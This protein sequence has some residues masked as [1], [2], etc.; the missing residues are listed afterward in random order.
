MGKSG[1]KTESTVTV[2][3]LFQALT[4]YLSVFAL[5][6][7]LLGTD[8][9]GRETVLNIVLFVCLLRLYSRKVRMNTYRRN[10]CRIF[11]GILSAVFVVGREVYNT[12]SAAGLF[13]ALPAILCTVLCLMGFYCL[14][15][16]LLGYPVRWLETQKA[17]PC[18]VTQWKLFR[19]RWRFLL[20]WGFIFLCWV[21]AFLAYYPG[22]LSYDSILQHRQVVGSLSGL[23]FAAYSNHHPPVH[24]YIWELFFRLGQHTY[25]EAI[26]MYAAVQMVILSLSFALVICYLIDRKWANWAV[27]LALLFVSVNP[28]MC[29]FSVSMT[30]DVYFTAAFVVVVLRLAQLAD[31]PAAFAASPVRMLSLG[32]CALMMCL[33]RNN[34]VYVLILM[35]PV[36]CLI[37]RKQWKQLLIS[38]GTALV[39]YFLIVGPGYSAL[40]I[41]SR[42]TGEVLSI[43]MQQ[44]ARVVTRREGELTE[45]D[46][47]EL[48][49]FLNYETYGAYNPRFA[50][51]VKNDFQDDYYQEH[52][53]EFFRLWLR[54]LK[55]FPGEYVDA[56][57]S[58]NVPYVFPDSATQDAYAQRIYIE[59]ENYMKPDRYSK[60]PGLLAFYRHFASYDA[61]KGIPLVSNLF[62][63]A[64]PFWV[65]L[66]GLFLLMVGMDWSGMTVILPG[67]LYQLT[68][69][70]GPVNNFRYVFPI[71]CIYPLI[72]C[73]IFSKKRN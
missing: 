61:V 71:F 29:I 21:P 9:F 62:S 66:F 4:A 53:S 16:R 32:F 43:P 57:L 55:R 65:M 45:E 15:D 48:G 12:N 68:F 46:K 10:C 59:Q 3:M 37:Y 27:V 64:A 42:N 60:L 38:C 51:P 18:R 50:D 39:L 63:T 17:S 19:C 47:E 11:A 44:L 73:V 67:L 1:R 5:D 40:G 54:L 7:Y 30:K 6:R 36:L 14:F 34:A 70:L 69:L 2:K 56:F 22:I 31:D 8:V 41:A 28:V 25:F 24:T 13:A 20:I 26:S 35:V 58:N 72:C 33:F 52:K 23:G 49:H